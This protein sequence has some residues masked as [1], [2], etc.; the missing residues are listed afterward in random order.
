MTTVRQEAGTSATTRRGAAR[1]WHFLLTTLLVLVSLP[2]FATAALAL[3][4][5]IGPIDVTATARRLVRDGVPGLSFQRV[6]LTWNG[7]REG[8]AAPL[9]LIVDGLRLDDARVG[10]ARARSAFVALD[11]PA[12]LRGRAV[13]L[14]LRAE[15]GG[16]DLSSEALHPASPQVGAGRSRL[17]F[18]ALRDVSLSRMVI[19]ARADGLSCRADLDALRLTPLHRP[20]AIGVTGRIAAALS[21]GPSGAQGP[22]LRIAGAAREGPSGEIVWHLATG[23]FVPA[24]LARGL[25]MLAPLAAPLSALALPLSLQLDARLSGGFGRLM[26]PRRAALTARLGA[27][28]IRSAGEDIAIGAGLLRLTLTL[29]DAPDGTVAVALLP[30]TVTLGAAGATDA[31]VLRLDGIARQTGAAIRA[32]LAIGLQRFDF[33]GLQ[34]LWPAFLAPGARRW[35]IGNIIA[36]DGNGLAARTE[37][38]S[39]AGWRDVHLSGLSGGLDAD[40]LTIFW[41]RPIAPLRDLDARLVLEGP[42]SLRIEGGDATE[43][44]PGHGAISIGRTV[45]RIT[46]LSHKQQLGRI[47]AQLAG[48][49]P[50]LLA[51]LSQ[52]RLRLLSRHP[53]PFSDTSGTASVRL[54]L[55]IPLLETV[56]ADDIPVQADATLSHVHLGGAVLGRAVDAA[57]LTLSAGNAGLRAQGNG[58]IGGIPARLAYA[59]DF[60]AGGVDQ[61]TE[62]G[63]ASAPLD[64][65]ALRRAG[66]DHA[67]LLHGSAR[68]DVD[69]AHHRSGAATVALAL[70]LTAAALATPVWSK[71]VGSPARA[72]AV[73]DLHD[74]RL[75]AI[76]AVQARGDGLSLDGHAL[77][78]DGA[79]SGLVIERFRV[80]RSEGAG[81]IDLPESD[82][83]HQVRVALHGATLDLT[84]LLDAAASPPRA[85]DLA[86]DAPPR[87]PPAWR[88]PAW[89]PPAWRPPAWRADLDFRRVL[90]AP[91]RSVG[92]VRLQAEARG[93]RIGM[94]RL[95]VDAP[96]PLRATVLPAAAGRE[97]RVQ[98]PDIGALLTALGLGTSIE[99]G[100]LTLTALMDDRLQ[101]SGIARIGRFTVHDAPL[102]AR[103]ARDLS[104]YGLQFGARSRQLVVTRFEAPFTLRGDLLRLSGA[105][106]SNAA[107]GSTLR[108]LIDLGQ[109]RL[110][111]RGTVVPSYL[112]NALPGKLPGV[113]RV[114]SPES[115]GGLLAL[116]LRVTG[117]FSAPVVKVNPLSL[118]A[119]GILRRLLFN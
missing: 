24:V 11:L 97:L 66:I 54:R 88:P 83:R 39:D 89:R 106:A 72:A 18:D 64:A 42:D 111:L 40:N 35:V 8:P 22:G 5:W 94:A 44:I 71:Q 26:L 92:G 84:P 45:M 76:D 47:D 21:C 13:V 30:S 56:A 63:H 58:A 85:G 112:I 114:F 6:R 61:V 62:R 36:G 91:N 31:P 82:P 38:T 77:V 98:A 1:W 68:L 103:L 60:R 25:P 79:P 10:Q 81:R 93:S 73:L 23:A 75:N 102:A 14:G 116:T 37:W 27:G 95:S 107:L 20:A 59:M 101:L 110:D 32:G 51:L 49:L 57:A 7:W 65:A 70:D 104:I 12:L 55:S 41:L 119:P 29:P 3:R 74:G 52:P 86:W 113:G 34:R 87:L 118:L 115:G 17:D 48:A 69:Y 90:F 4:L 80:G 108:G 100:A 50:D 43:T 46:G 105:H 78:A 28:V 53:L 9:G 19:A 96:S 15:D 16:I 33:A 2:V 67:D 117:P 109:D 99:G